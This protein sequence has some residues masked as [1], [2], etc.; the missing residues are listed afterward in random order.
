MITDFALLSIIRFI[1]DI[2]DPNRSLEESEAL[3]VQFENILLNQ[4]NDRVNFSSTARAYLRLEP[5]D[6]PLISSRV[7]R[8]FWQK[9]TQATDDI[10]AFLFDQ[11]L[12][13]LYALIDDPFVRYDIVRFLLDQSPD[14]LDN[15]FNQ[16]TNN[17]NNDIEPVN[18]WIRIREL[19]DILFDIQASYGI[20]RPILEIINRWVRERSD[21]RNEFRNFLRYRPEYLVGDIGIEIF[22]FLNLDDAI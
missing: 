16:F 22:T 20:S 17:R 14:T 5:E 13:G 10:S 4:D 2:H 3:R 8:W 12:A 21:L 15:I 6:L 1:E 7:H 19:I 11:N 18:R 9:L